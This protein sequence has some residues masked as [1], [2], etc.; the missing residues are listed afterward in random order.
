MPLVFFSGSL[1]STS[2]RP[3]FIDVCEARLLSCHG[4]YLPTARQWLAEA[5]NHPLSKQRYIMLDS[6]AFTAWS[7][8][9]HITLNE[10][11]RNYSAIIDRYGPYYSK[12]YVINLDVIPGRR[13]V[14]PTRSEI[15]QALI[16]SDRNFAQL[17]DRFGDAVLPVFHQGEPRERLQVVAQQN[18]SF[19]CVSPRNDLGEAQRVPWAERVHS[20]IPGIPTHGL[21][22]TGVDMMLGVPWYS[23]DSATWVQVAG[24]GGILI[25]SDEALKVIAIS[26][27]SPARRFYGD[28]YDSTT[29]DIRRRIEVMADRIGVTID[30]LQSL[31][32]G[33]EWFNVNTLKRISSYPARPAR[34]QMT[35]WE[36]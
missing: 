14:T 15:E 25:E 2:H 31:P 6:G 35:L 7:K 24:F 26:K 13:G 18:P 21:A 17:F 20:E 30:E 1:G 5:H 32:G 11:I 16:D 28:H 12:I 23:V 22:A 27:E 19:I 33:R 29:P 4:S 36:F 34:P 8:G 3:R 10:V 9:E